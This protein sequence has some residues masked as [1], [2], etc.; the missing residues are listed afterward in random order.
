M[1]FNVLDRPKRR[2][3]T[4][5]FLHSTAASLMFHGGPFHHTLDHHSLP[6]SP[7]YWQPNHSRMAK[8]SRGLGRPSMSMGSMPP[9]ATKGSFWKR[10]TSTPQNPVHH[11]SLPSPSNPPAVAFRAGKD[12]GSN[13]HVE[14]EH[15]NEQMEA[16]RYGSDRN[17]PNHI[18]RYV[19]FLFSICFLG[20]W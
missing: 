6:V 14:P 8:D 10:Q 5:F 1:V 4:V 16:R 2:L 13:K 15:R 3:L 20:S 7:S 17:P 19:V 11:S 18:E 9:P 12:A